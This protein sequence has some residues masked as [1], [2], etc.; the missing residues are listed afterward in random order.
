V[1]QLPLLFAQRT[2]LNRSSVM[3]SLKA[4]MCRWQDY[5]SVEQRE[6]GYQDVYWAV[7]IMSGAGGGHEPSGISWLSDIFSLA[8][9][10]CSL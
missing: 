6:V 2:W 4:D 9:G 5:V 3:A 1:V 7:W 8:K 10:F